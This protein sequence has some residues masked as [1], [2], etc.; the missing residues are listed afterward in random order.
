MIQQLKKNEIIYPDCHGQPMSDNTSQ[1]NWTVKIKEN[2][3]V[4]FA[5]NPNVFVA[6]DLLWYWLE[7]VSCLQTI[8]Y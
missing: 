7:G 8:Y 6:G 4:L 3:Q 2:L 1:F 5:S